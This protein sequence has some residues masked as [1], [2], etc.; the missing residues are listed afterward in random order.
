M[1]ILGPDGRPIPGHGRA[2][3]A[4]AKGDSV[5]VQ[6]GEDTYNAN[7][8][9]VLMEMARAQRNGW[10]QKQIIA[11]WQLVGQATSPFYLE[12]ALEKGRMLLD[13][14]IRRGLIPEDSK[15]SDPIDYSRVK[16]DD[17]DL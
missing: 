6:I 9:H 16:F 14:A 15:I 7:P 8:L 2:M 3:T 10:S 5:T 1:T 13:E 4:E 11:H 12:R 17:D